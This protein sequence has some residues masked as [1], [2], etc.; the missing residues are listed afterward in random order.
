MGQSNMDFENQI[1]EKEYVNSYQ[2]KSDNFE[3]KLY[4]LI[5]STDTQTI[6]ADIFAKLNYKSVENLLEPIRG[7]SLDITINASLDNPFDEF[8][9]FNEYDYGVVFKRNGYNIF[10]GYINPEG[11]TQSFTSIN[12]QANL[13]A[14]DNLGS[15][16]NIE[17]KRENEYPTE[18]QFLIRIL[19]KTQLNLPIAY[20][21]DIN[22]VYKNKNS[23]NFLLGQDF[24]QEDERLINPEVFTNKNDRGIDCET[25]IK[26]IFQ[27]YN[28]CL[29]MASIP[30][31]DDTDTYI[32]DRVCWVIFRPE[33]LYQNKLAYN[34]GFKVIEWSEVPVI[35]NKGVLGNVEVIEPLNTY[36]T[37][38]INSRIKSDID[39]VS[40]FT[41]I[42]INANQLIR[43][44]NA[45]QNFRF[46][47]I[48]V[49]KPSVFE[50]KFDNFTPNSFQ[51]PPLW[52]DDNGDLGF[53]SWAGLPNEKRI[54]FESD[55]IK[56][57]DEATEINING[58]GTIERL[59]DGTY[60]GWEG[61]FDV[62]IVHQTLEGDLFQFRIAPTTSGGDDSPT[63][64]FINNF[65]SL[66]TGNVWFAPLLRQRLDNVFDG[67]FEFNVEL[68]KLFSKG[69]NLKIYF[70]TFSIPDDINYRRFQLI[71]KDFNVKVLAPAQLGKGEYH[72]A[73]RLNQIS[74]KL[75]DPV[76]VINAD[77]TTN[78]F[79]NGLKRKIITEVNPINYDFWS[80][81]SR[82]QDI[83]QPY[84]NR[85]LELMSL[86]RLRI[87]QQSM[88]I[89]SG[90]IYFYMPYVSVVRYADLP[91]KVFGVINYQYNTIT[92]VTSLTCME[93]K[94]SGNDN[95]YKYENSIIFEDEKNK[96]IEQ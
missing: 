13:V 30:I 34:Y 1:W 96:L 58:N 47:Q 82:V 64:V 52:F 27:K 85:L 14:V 48:W 49:D 59:I 32:D 42:H 68:P 38:R 62:T 8:L 17:F 65:A 63:W 69:G 28:A 92:N 73:E 56:L 9:T 80:T 79:K 89:F 57:P 10:K 41:N 83:S 4:K 50:Y 36:R 60:T 37:K 2:N 51:T 40:F 70:S 35:K 16:K 31:Y 11:I 21:D 20:I 5:P 12:W 90:D 93:I 39:G 33:F 44:R 84:Q 24:W 81:I 72:D 67:E 15:L 74:S 19:R 91:G 66:N 29:T 75:D 23:S 54:Q 76:K 77:E 45:L 86:E 3:I 25:I 94:I 78:F 95:N 22:V 88:L 87:R 43:G 53:K 6:N 26:D 61:K 7:V 55:L 46:E 71:L 18:N